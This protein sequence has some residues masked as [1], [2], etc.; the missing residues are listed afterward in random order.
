MFKTKDITK[1][2]LSE[3]IDFNNKEH[4]DAFKVM[5][6]TGTWPVSFMDTLNT[7]VHYESG[8]WYTNLMSKAVVALM[9]MVDQPVIDNP[10]SPP[11]FDNPL[12]LTQD[13]KE[14]MIICLNS[15]SREGQMSDNFSNGGPKEFAD[16][17]YDGDMTQA[18][19]LI[20]SLEGKG[21]GWLDDRDGDLNVCVDDQGN[22]KTVAL[23]DKI[24]WLTEDGVNAIFDLTDQE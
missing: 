2:P 4:Y 10:L 5:V 9:E 14:A 17:L 15:D 6:H 23:A 24:F 19:E 21:V 18:Q 1:V 13:E 7:H 12:N 20:A 3:F 16:D 8:R 11:V 22:P